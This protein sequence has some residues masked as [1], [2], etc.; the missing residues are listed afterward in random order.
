MTLRALLIQRAARLQDRPAFSG[1]PWPTLS[2]AQL[3]NRAEG[4]GFGLLAEGIPEA[5]F[6]TGHGPW[7]W[8]A[9]LAAAVA[10][11]PWDPA[12]ARLDPRVL[13][14]PRFNDDHGRGPLHDREEAVAEDTPF[15]PGLTQGELLRRL[16][17][18]NQALG[19]DH[20]TV[21]ALPLEAWGS[22]ALRGALWSALYAGAHA[23]VAP[24]PPPPG[25]LARWLGPKPAPAFDPAPFLTLGL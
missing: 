7:D 23:I 24:A 14:G 13:G 21:V 1:A 22:P 3:R 9:E 12:A 6:A 5:T 18:L 8:M 4:V 15:A 19:W 17:R 16:V 11:V 20:D 25:R 2:Y 10:G